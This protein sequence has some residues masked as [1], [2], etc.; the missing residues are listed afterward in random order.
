MDTQT[1]GST[2]SA[3]TN[4]VPQHYDKLGV[5]LF[6]GDFIAAPCVLRKIQIAKIIKLNPKMLKICKIG[7]K[8]NTN[9][10]ANETVKLD[11]ALVTMYILRNEKK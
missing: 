10:Y 6:P 1:T 9:T 2:Q 3:K 8:Y 11:P 5:E 4:K 7:T